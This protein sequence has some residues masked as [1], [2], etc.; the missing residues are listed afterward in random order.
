MHC[1]SQ[2]NVPDSR[3]RTLE[4]SLSA[5]TLLLCAYILSMNL[6]D[7]D[8]WG[9]VRYGQDP[10]RDGV[11]PATS[12]YTF[13]AENYRWINH[14][15]L[16]EVVFAV[17]RFWQ[18]YRMLVSTLPGRS[19]TSNFSFNDKPKAM[20]LPYSTLAASRRWSL[21]LTVKRT[22]GGYMVACG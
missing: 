13:T 12:T 14:E 18:S 16:C 17:S 4:R 9:H 5:L 20:S 19:G 10:L 22:S 8:L 15:N 6:A 7:P 1:D 3:K 21:R 2:L 11:L